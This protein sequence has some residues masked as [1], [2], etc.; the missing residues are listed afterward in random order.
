LQVKAFEKTG[1][2]GAYHEPFDVDCENFMEKSRG[3]AV[4]IAGCRRLLDRCV[5]QANTSDP[6]EVCQAFDIIFGLLDRIDEGRERLVFADEDG[7]W[8]VG[9]DWEEVLPRW[10]KVLSATAAP[11]QYWRRIDVL[12][13]GHYRYGSARMVAVARKAA[14]PAQRHA[15]GTR[16]GRARPLRPARSR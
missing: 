1:L 4:W 8:Q 11:E 10:F 2:A 9:V 15:L 7:A 5:R 13:E 6:G 3:T 14:T 16:S 12:L